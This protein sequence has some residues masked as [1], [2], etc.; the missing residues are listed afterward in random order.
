MVALV[1][2]AAVVILLLVVR[3]IHQLNPHLKEIMVAMQ[4]R[5]QQAVMAVVVAVA[6]LPLL[7]IMVLTHQVE[8]VVLGA[9]EPHHQLQEHLLLV[10]VAVA[11]GE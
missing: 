8:W 2:A 3:E 11:V 9:Q 7:V 6:V 10:L 4:T 1:V 5:Q